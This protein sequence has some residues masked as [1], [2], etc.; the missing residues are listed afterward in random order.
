[1]F[2]SRRFSSSSSLS[3]DIMTHSSHHIL[4]ATYR[5]WLYSCHTQDISQEQ[6]VPH[7]LVR[8][9]PWS[10]CPCSVIFYV[11][12]LYSMYDKILLFRP[13]NFR[14]NSLMFTV[15]KYKYCRLGVI[16]DRKI[17]LARKFNLA[18]DI[19]EYIV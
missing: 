1:M 11:A 14:V 7:R 12:Q 6:A 16:S 3:W 18:L 5:I 4:H 17:L 15:I 2:F 19:G 13:I 10:G 8:V 9:C